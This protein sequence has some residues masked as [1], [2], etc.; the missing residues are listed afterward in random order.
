MKIHGV[1]IEMEERVCI[2]G[3]GQKFRCMKSSTTQYAKADC[4]SVCLEFRNDLDKCGWQNISL[5]AMDKTK[6]FPKKGFE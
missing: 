2:G 6:P 4:G 3:C 1:D 5:E